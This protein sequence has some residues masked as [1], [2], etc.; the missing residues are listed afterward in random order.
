MWN[1]AAVPAYVE[2]LRAKDGPYG[3]Y[4]I[5]AVNA[6][7]FYASCA[8]AFLRQLIGDLDRL[9]PAERAEWVG[10]IQS[11][12]DPATGWFESPERGVPSPVHDD[13]YFRLQ[14]AT[15]AISALDALGEKPKY[16]FRAVHD[17]HAPGAIEDWLARRVWSQPW[18]AGNEVMFLA[19]LLITDSEVHGLA[20]ARAALERWFAWHDARQDERTGFWGEGRITATLDGMGGAMHQFMIYFRQQRPLARVDLIIDFTLRLEMPDGMY[21]PAWGGGGC[22]EYDAAVVLAKLMERTGHR[23]ADIAASFQRMHA[24]IVKLQNPDGGFRWSERGPVTAAMWARQLASLAKHGDPYYWYLINRRLMGRAVGRHGPARSVKPWG[25]VDVRWEESDLYA[26]WM[27]IMALGHIAEVID[28]P[29]RAMP[30]HWLSAPGLGW[31]GP[32]ACAA[33]IR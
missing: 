9:T 23:R 10:W 32:A 6:P 22:E 25:A 33:R 31:N 24:A 2:S 18:V 12:Q 7:S 4:A 15:F 1:P 20:P 8:A 16:P 11:H 28:T 27:R 17:L 21:N 5:S 26:T 29:E 13:N 3:R 30:F 19:I 14:R